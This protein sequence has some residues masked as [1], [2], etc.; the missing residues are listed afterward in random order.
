MLII[1]IGVLMRPLL[2]VLMRRWEII[3]IHL[4][5]LILRAVMVRL[6]SLLCCFILVGVLIPSFL[7]VLLIL[8][9]KGPLLL[10]TRVLMFVVLLL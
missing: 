5:L 9:H 10:L 3:L 4:M 1:L 2:L 6:F 7:S 8:L